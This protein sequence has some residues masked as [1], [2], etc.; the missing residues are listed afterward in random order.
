M[1]DFEIHR[2]KGIL[3]FDDNT[4]KIIQAVREVFEIRDSDSE[5][6]QSKVCKIILIGRGLGH[7]GSVWRESFG[8]FV[9]VD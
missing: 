9:G 7:D 3:I 2:L 6:P 1:E 8:R 5:P 4:T